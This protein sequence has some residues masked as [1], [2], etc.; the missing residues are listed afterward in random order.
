MKVFDEKFK[1]NKLRYVLQSGLATL[2]VFLILFILDTV[3]DAVV[4]A[5]FGASSFIAF[6]MPEAQVSKPRFLIG[7]Y[8]VGIISGSVLNMLACS[9]MLLP[10]SLIQQY[11]HVIFGALSVG[12][13]IFLMVI[14]NTEHPPAAAVALSIII[15]ENSFWALFVTVMGIILISAIKAALK[16]FLKNLL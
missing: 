8:L 15:N 10:F 12:L 16:P 4:I 5:A 14:T 2:S 9:E 6:T 1:S 13:A 11:N 3:S 7:G